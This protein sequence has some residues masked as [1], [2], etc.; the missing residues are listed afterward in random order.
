MKRL[1][2]L[3]VLSSLLIL[4]LA[5]VV[6]ADTKPVLKSEEVVQSQP[7]KAEEPTLNSSTPVRLTAPQAYQLNW[8]SINGGGAISASS[9]SYR[10]GLSIGQSAAGTASSPS[11]QLGVGFWYGVAP[12]SACAAAKGDL[13][14]S[15]NLSGADIVLLVRCVFNSDGTGTV[16]GDCNLCYTDTNCSG[17][18]S[19]SDIVLVISA[20]FNQTPFPC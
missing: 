12:S 17:G 8:L 1:K 10:L 4:T 2:V 13:N 14:G 20:T 18:L 7:A 15:G 19:A 5:V 3:L 9:P 16:G 6:A 11:Y